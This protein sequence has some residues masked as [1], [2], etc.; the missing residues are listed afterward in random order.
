M[1]LIE[2]TPKIGV[3]N[4]FDKAV[5][6]YPNPVTDGYV[7]INFFDKSNGNVNINIYNVNGQLIK[8]F[9]ICISQLRTLLKDSIL[10]TL[11]KGV[12][13]VELQV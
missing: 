7:N 6:V 2:S 4:T 1:I 5:N 8:N 9:T 13:M 11:T 12:Y 3:V 10:T